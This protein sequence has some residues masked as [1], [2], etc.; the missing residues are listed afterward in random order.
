[1]PTLAIFQ[2]YRGMMF[3]TDSAIQKITQIIILMQYKTYN[4]Y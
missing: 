3:Y 2:L 1:M 4:I